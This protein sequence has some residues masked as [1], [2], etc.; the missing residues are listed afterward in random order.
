MRQLIFIEPGRLEWADVP[1]PIIRGTKEAIVAPLVMGRCDLDALYLSGRM[2]LA[3][4]EPIGHEMIGEIVDLGDSAAKSFH[5]GQRVIV[6]AQIS[7]GECRYCMAGQSGRCQSVPFGASYGM[8]REGNYGGAVSEY[9]HV[10]FASGMLVPIPQDS[11]MTEMMGL[12]DMATD[13]WRAVGPQLEAVKQGTVLVVGGGTPVIGIYAAGLACSLKASR[14][15]YVD[16]SNARTGVAAKY[17]AETYSHIDEVPNCEF[18]IVVD[19]ANDPVG[20]S[21]ALAACGPAA[22][23]T[24]VAPPFEMPKL[25]VMAAY[26][27]GL[28]YTLARPNCRHGHEPVLQAWSSKGFRPDI[29]GPK[30]FKF[31]QAP[32]AWL[33]EALYVAVTRD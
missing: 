32:E 23:L 2:P 30:L 33:D 25:P 17:G 9:V 29:V 6:P 26:N 12:T 28:T 14:V 3:S 24:S 16:A 18:D 10:P 11:I 22:H 1:K 15:V 19:A 21:A 27:K 13:A 20:F 4:G 7:C 31:A 5:I 8:G